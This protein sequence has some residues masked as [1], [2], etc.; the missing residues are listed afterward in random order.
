MVLFL[1]IFGVF[2]GVLLVSGLRL[3]LDLFLADLVFDLKFSR[4]YFSSYRLRTNLS[5]RVSL[6]LKLS[7]IKGWL[8][9]SSH[10]ILSSSLIFRQLLMKSFDLSVILVLNGMGLVIIL[11]K[12]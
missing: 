10:D 8:N 9:A 11:F 3:M 7:S 5:S 6:K 1:H 4:F 2:R 12:S